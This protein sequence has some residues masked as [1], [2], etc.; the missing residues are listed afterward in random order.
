MFCC[1]FFRPQ[2]EGEE[3]TFFEVEMGVDSEFY[4]SKKN[5]PAIEEGNVVTF[6]YDNDDSGVP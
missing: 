4:N 5:T 2:N 3:K 1:N 6:R